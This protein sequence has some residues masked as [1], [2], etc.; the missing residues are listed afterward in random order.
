MDVPQI[1]SVFRK[2]DE[3]GY[4]HKI[5]DQNRIV[6]YGL[7]NF[8]ALEMFS[9]STKQYGIRGM[10]IQTSPHQSRKMVWVTEGRI[11]DVVVNVCSR[12]VYT[13]E[14]G[15]ESEYVLYVPKNFAHGFQALSIKATVNYLT[16]TQYQPKFDTGFNP[17]S[18]GFDWPR[19]V[20]VLSDRDRNLKDFEEFCA[21][22]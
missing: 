21:E 8:H 11:L 5:L 22:F 19:P 12:E 1:I 10:H 18:F 16:D 17:L 6:E 3:R 20:S 13:F 15:E 7:G 14:L 9:T 2:N 4:F